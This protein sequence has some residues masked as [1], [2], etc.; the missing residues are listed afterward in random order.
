MLRMAK[1]TDSSIFTIWMKRGEYAETQKM[2]E[3]FTPDATV[4]NLRDVIP[5]IK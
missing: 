2:H 5:L 1:K 4:N 3:D